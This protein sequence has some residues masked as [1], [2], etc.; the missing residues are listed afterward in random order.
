MPQPSTSRRTSRK[1]A[2]TSPPESRSTAAFAVRAGR[3][4]ALRVVSICSPRRATSGRSASGTCTRKIDSQ[5]STS[6]RIPPRAGP[7]AAP[8]MPAA[9]HSRTARPP[10][11]S[12]EARRPSAAVTSNAAPTAC[13][14]RA[15]TRTSK[16]GA[17][18]QSE[19]GCR[20]DQGSRDE[21]CARCSSGDEGSR[22]RNQSEREV[23]RR[24]HPG[25]GGDVDVELPK[26][27]GK[28]ERDDR[29]IGERE[30]D[31]E[32]DQARPHE[33]SLGGLTESR[34]HDP[35]GDCARST[36][37]CATHTRGTPRRENSST[38]RL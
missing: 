30:P 4:A 1:S 38:R 29:R 20:E 17:S 36:E 24:Q 2:A 3:P 14:M 35:F 27:V 21:D 7:S 22:Q 33:T 19:R 5:P 18:P 23:E 25:N 32:T 8:K 11:P 12:V 13:A 26:H 31:R 37:V 28:R 9:T 15:P 34:A 10:F 16:D 6:V